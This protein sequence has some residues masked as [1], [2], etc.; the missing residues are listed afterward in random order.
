MIETKVKTIAD[1]EPTLE[2]CQEFVG[3]LIAIVPLMDGSQMI[4]NEDGLLL[5]LPHN[6]KASQMAGQDLVGNA[7]VLRGDARLT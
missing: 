1:K 4:V 2:E 7:L 6:D 3:G 5:K